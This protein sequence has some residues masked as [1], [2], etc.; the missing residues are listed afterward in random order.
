MNL[1]HPEQEKPAPTAPAHPALDHNARFHQSA[2]LRGI[3]Q[4]QRSGD[5]EAYGV[6]PLVAPV[7]VTS[8]GPGE[9][10]E[11]PQGGQYSVYKDLNFDIMKQLKRA[12]SLYG[13]RS[14]YTRE[15]LEALVIN[16]N[17]IPVD[18]DVL[19]RACLSSA[20]F[21]QFKTWWADAARQQEMRNQ[22]A[23]PPVPITAEQLT[24]TGQ[25]VGFHVQRQFS[26]QA[27]DQLRMCCLKAW[28]KIIP[29]GETIPP[30]A[31][32]KQ[33]LN[34]PYEEFVER[35]ND[36][37]IRTVNEPGLRI[38]L[39]RMLAF[40]NANNEC[41][42]VLFPIKLNNGNLEDY[43]RTCRDVGSPT[44]NANLLAAALK[45]LNSGKVK[46]NC[47]RCGKPGHMKKDCRS[48]KPPSNPHSLDRDPGTSSSYNSQ[49]LAPGIGPQSEK[50]KP[51]ANQGHSKFDREGNGASSGNGKQG[52]ASGPNKHNTRLI[53]QCP[54]QT[55]NQPGCE[56]SLISTLQPQE[57][58]PLI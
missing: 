57:V 41:R 27:V 30:V 20:E 24:G 45:N 38:I 13:L 14:P 37:L 10:L 28:D 47:F 6:R 18:W 19:S 43:I 12:I 21:L 7:T 26:L 8:F 58:R 3:R 52:P 4:A 32:V 11:Y 53:Q 29:S 2:L 1:P 55:H 51:W 39:L 34:E 15:F 56:W 42:R 49:N 40:E 36:N 9:I 16:E 5:V 17:F 44:Y 48:E 25:W 23:D 50:G 35:L 33:G 31:Q 54:S 46:G 22:A